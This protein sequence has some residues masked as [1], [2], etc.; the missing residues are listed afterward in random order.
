VNLAVPGLRWVFACYPLVGFQMVSSAFFQSI[1]R[2]Y[3]S[4]ILAMTRQLIF[5]VPILLIL[6]HFLG[7]TGV[8]LSMTLADL[9]SIALAIFLLSGELKKITIK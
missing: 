8:W 3:K 2:A 6:P 5:L 7:T 1:G 9:L 4:I